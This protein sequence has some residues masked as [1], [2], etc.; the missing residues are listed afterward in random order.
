MQRTR[1]EFHRLK[2]IEEAVAVERDPAEL[3]N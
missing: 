3:L 2:A 1:N